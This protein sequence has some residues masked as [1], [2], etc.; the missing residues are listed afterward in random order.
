[1]ATMTEEKPTGTKV[2]AGVVAEPFRQQVK[3]RERLTLTPPSASMFG[4]VCVRNREE[5]F[6]NLW[7][8][9]SWGI[10]ARDAR[11]QN[12]DVVRG[13]LCAL[14]QC[15]PR[16]SLPCCQ[17][18]SAVYFVEDAPHKRGAGLHR[19]S[20]GGWRMLHFVYPWIVVRRQQ[21]SGGVI[22]CD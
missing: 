17:P 22:G 20:C 14:L 6:L 19:Y 12:I 8:P 11:R 7:S 4:H 10:M 5:L 16:N 13:K 21:I 18:P 2:D 9:A 1:M 15:W 3:N